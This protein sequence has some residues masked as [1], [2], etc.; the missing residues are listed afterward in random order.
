MVLTPTP[1]PFIFFDPRGEP[2]LLPEDDPALHNS[3]TDRDGF[4]QAAAQAFNDEVHQVDDVEEVPPDFVH[5]HV[6]D[7]VS[8]ARECM[9]RRRCIDEGGPSFT[10]CF[11]PKG[12]LYI[13]VLEALDSIGFTTGHD[14]DKFTLI[15]HPLVP[16][17]KPRL[18]RHRGGI[19]LQYATEDDIRQA[20]L[21]DAKAFAHWFVRPI[22]GRTWKVGDPWPPPVEI[23][24]PSVWVMLS[25]RQRRAIARDLRD[26]IDNFP[27][28]FIEERPTLAWRIDGEHVQSLGCTNA[29]VTPEMT[30]DEKCLKCR[31]GPDSDHAHI[32]PFL[33]MVRIAPDGKVHLVP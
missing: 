31:I 32:D 13:G 33:D 9:T 11:R 25:A 1:S 24:D 26:S 23:D 28:V 18:V 5:I 17:P 27:R 30:P 3:P 20:A 2:E 8:M 7:A 22:D 21:A 19:D 4:V 29:A 16:M 12:A 6:Y 10:V 14:I 15:R